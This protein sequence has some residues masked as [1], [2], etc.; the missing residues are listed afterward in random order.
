MN[1][2]NK[3][4]KYQL[5]ALLH[6]CDDTAG[7]HILWVDHL[8]EVQVTMLADESPAQWSTIMDKKIRF[9][10]QSYAMRNGYV[11]E[12]AASDED[13]VSSLFE[14]LL[15]DWQAGTIGVIE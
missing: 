5:Q 6:V 10:Y 9:R 13:Y 2:N 8:G 12:K 1:L 14:R 3:P 4:S 11:G 7:H 15:T